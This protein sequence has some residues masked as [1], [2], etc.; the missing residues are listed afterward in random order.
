MKKKFIDHNFYA[1]TRDLLS[2]CDAIST[3]FA[4][5]GY[6]LTLRQ[7]HYQ[8]VSTNRIAN[9]E[10]EYKN[11]GHIVTEGRLA[12][13]L[14]WEHITDRVRLI[15]QNTHWLDPEDIIQSVSETDHRHMGRTTLPP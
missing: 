7:L 4:K 11:L 10:K 2:E 9:T 15:N 1:K 3:V 14:D 5:N 12:R 13:I 8:L 6:T